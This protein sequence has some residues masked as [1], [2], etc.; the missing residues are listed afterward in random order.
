M[1]LF[2]SS[3]LWALYMMSWC[4][5]FDKVF[6]VCLFLF[7]SI[8]LFACSSTYHRTKWTMAQLNQEALFGK[9]DYTF[10][11]FMVAFSFAPVYICQVPNGGGL[12]VIGLLFITVV[13]GTLLTF[14]PIEVGRH[15]LVLIYITQ[16][17]VQIMP[18]STNLWCPNIW[19]QLMVTEQHLVYA[20]GICYLVGS[21][22][23][24]RRWPDPL[25]SYFGYHE[26]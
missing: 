13:A 2:R 1:V 25:P 5:T 16:A 24:A 22:I 23:F 17:M 21:Q 8:G 19:G 10:I 3:P 20:M 6:A 26:I 18:L 9:L 12:V 15:T 14:G 7:A 11:F 4:S